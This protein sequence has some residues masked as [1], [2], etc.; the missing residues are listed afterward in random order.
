[1]SYEED[2]TLVEAANVMFGNDRVSA[3]KWLGT[4]NKAFNWRTPL[5]NARLEGGKEEVLAYIDK[6][7]LYERSN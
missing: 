1:M 3:W 4:P 7:S 2:T 6:W 5:S